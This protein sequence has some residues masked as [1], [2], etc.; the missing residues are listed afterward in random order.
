MDLGLSLFSTEQSGRVGDIAGEVERLGFE[1]LWFPEHML[2]PVRYK[3]RYK[4]APDGKVPE[5]F[6]HL[7]DPFIAA[8]MAAQA[9]DHLRVATGICILPQRDIIAT[10]KA[11]ATLDRHC[12]GRFIMGVGAGWFPEEAEILGVPFK[13][14]WKAL[15][16]GVEALKVLWTMEEA[17]YDGEF[18]RFPPVRL[19]P[20]PLQ[21]PHPP[22][23][24]GIHDPRYAPARVA[25]YADGWCPGD[26]PVDEAADAVASVCRAAEARGRDAGG[27]EFSVVLTP[28]GSFPALEDMVRYR[29]AGIRRIILRVMEAATGSGV[30]AVRRLR[31]FLEQARRLDP[32][33]TRQDPMR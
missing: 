6:A 13:R 27:M 2:I 29:A 30:A 7:P 9:T 15:R 17:A 18:V 11:A 1:S 23:V 31:R 3:S 25:R 33:P 28:D 32:Q 14:R 12:G 26:L 24:L 21:K 16:E 4:R 10:A 8:A 19:F 22:V 5:S 20:K